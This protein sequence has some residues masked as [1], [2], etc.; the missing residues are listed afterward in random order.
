MAKQPPKRPRAAAKTPKQAVETPVVTESGN[1]TADIIP[2]EVHAKAPPLPAPVQKTA[3][4]DPVAETPK[5]APSQPAPEKTAPPP[6]RSGSRFLPL[7][8]GGIIAGAAGFAVAY[9]YLPQTQTNLDDVLS[10]RDAR[11]DALEQQVAALEPVDLT[12]VTDAQ[13]D[14]AAQL[15][16][17]QDEFAAMT[18][19]LNDR[20]AALDGASGGAAPA[21]EGFE[22]DISA[23]RAELAELSD[24]ARTELDSA[25]AEAAAIEENA[26]AA[27]RNAA[28]RAALARLQTS[29]ESGAPLGAALT[30]LQDVLGEPVPDSL[31]AV[32][33]GMPSLAALQDSFPDYARSALTAARAAGVAGEETSG[34]GAFLRNQFEVRS[35]NPRD[36]DT[37]DAIL[38]RAQA[39]LRNGML[40]DTLAELDPLPDVARAEMSDWIALAETRA[41]AIDAIETL[42][43]SLRDN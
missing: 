6:S 21:T 19:D 12:S 23:L 25:R 39:A 28:G 9:F 27:A 37:V 7:V 8:L 34:I 32:Q 4:P 36:G 10:S 13:S 43:S 18:A 35:V 11:L 1:V 20:I 16:I 24:M 22:A 2:P 33:D 31:L 14:F 41:D 30:D 40:G 26:A 38:S 42:A 17:L 5:P 3:S 29:V 15:A